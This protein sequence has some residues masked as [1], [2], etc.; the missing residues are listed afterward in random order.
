M[1]PL[2]TVD[3]AVRQSELK[4]G[5]V[6]LPLVVSQPTR[7]SWDAG[8]NLW[9]HAIRNEDEQEQARLAPL[10]VRALEHMDREA[11]QSGARTAVE[12]GEVSGS[13]QGSQRPVAPSPNLRSPA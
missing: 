5:S 9:V 13:G 12:R 11:T 7:R 8:W 3:Q 2:R 10:L 4:W 1:T 6:W